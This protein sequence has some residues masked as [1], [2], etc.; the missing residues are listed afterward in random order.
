MI[1]RLQYKLLLVFPSSRSCFRC[2]GCAAVNE[3]L[4]LKCSIGRRE[5]S[6]DIGVIADYDSLGR[7]SEEDLEAS[8]PCI[9]VI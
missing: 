1:S 4:L 2:V 8:Q 9:R 5:I 6:P 3:L 7:K